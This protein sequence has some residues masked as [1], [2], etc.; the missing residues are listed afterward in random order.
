MAK[1]KETTELLRII[2]SVSQLSV[3]RIVS[4]WCEEVAQ[5]MGARGRRSALCE[6]LVSQMG[7]GAESKAVSTLGVRMIDESCLLPILNDTGQ[8]LQ[9]RQV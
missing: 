9:P 7:L 3:C 5:H 8:L 1:N 6:I 2:F 4:D